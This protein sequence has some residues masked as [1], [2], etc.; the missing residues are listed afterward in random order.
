[1]LSPGHRKLLQNVLEWGRAL[2]KSPPPFASEKLL[3]LAKALENFRD[4]PQIEISKLAALSVHLQPEMTA[5][6]LA[7]VIVPIERALQKNIRDDDFLIT[8]EDRPTERK[9]YPLRLVLD[10]LRSAF[11]VGSIFRTAEGLGVEKIFLTGYTPSPEE[12]KTAKSTLGA[13]VPWEKALSLSDLIEEHR[14]EGWQII[15]LE[16]AQKAL[17]LS[18]PFAQVPTLLVFGNERFGLEPPQLSL[19]DEVR[20]LPLSGVKNSLNVAVMAGVAI[21]EW[22]RQWPTS[23]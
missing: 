5:R 11:N 1:M 21:Y 17:P 23:R 20:E 13:K 7:S 14:R 9:T 12:D 8:S 6:T 19:C 10:H 2:E 18:A 15:A 4:H 22:T 3:A 16:T